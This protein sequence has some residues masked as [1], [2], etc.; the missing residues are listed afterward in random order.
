MKKTISGIRGIVGDDLSV[1]DVMEFCSNF[2]M[3]GNSK[4]VIARDTR[5][6]GAMLKE[7]RDGF[8]NCSTPVVF[9]KNYYKIPSHLQRRD[10]RPRCH[11]FQRWFSSFDFIH[12]GFL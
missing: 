2:C 11:V 5:P 1:A 4:C 3:L 10:R 9:C 8:G 7:C 6:S 12:K